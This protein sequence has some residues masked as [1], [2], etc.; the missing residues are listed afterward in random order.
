VP[1]LQVGGGAGSHLLLGHVIRKWTVNM[2][3]CKGHRTQTRCTARNSFYFVYDS[4]M[5]IKNYTLLFLAGEDNTAR[6]DSWRYNY[7]F[8]Q[9]T[10]LECHGKMAP[11]FAFFLSC[12]FFRFSLDNVHWP[13]T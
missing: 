4:S 5:P 12:S 10:F 8:S 7:Y 3:L 13:E 1:M 9:I 6:F 2:I 11:I